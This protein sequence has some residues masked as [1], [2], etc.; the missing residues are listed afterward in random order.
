MRC[1]LV[2]VLGALAGPGVAAAACPD[3]PKAN[4]SGYAPP[5]NTAS[6]P[7]ADAGPEILHRAP[8]VSPQL[9]NTRNWQA[10]PILISGAQ[11]YRGGE[12]VAQDFLYDDRA[13]TYPGDAA[14]ARNAADIVEVRVEPLARATAIRVTL[15]SMVDVDHAAA[16]TVGLGDSDQ[17]RALP[18]NAGVSERAEVFVTAHGCGGDAVRASDT[19]ALPAPTV[20]TDVTRRQV[21]I[22]LPYTAFDPRGRT[23]KV[24]AAAGLWDKNANAYLRP[25][26]ARPAFFNVAFRG[27]GQWTINTWKDESQ[28]AALAAGDLSPLHADV[29]FAKLAAR[30]DDESGVPT[31]GPMNRILVSHFET[32]QGRGNSSGGDIL[33]NYACDPPACTYQ[34]SGRLQPYSVYVPDVAMPKDR[35][36][37]VLTMHGAN[38]NHNHFENGSTEPPLSVWR[39]LAQEGNPSIMVLPNARGMTYCYFGMAGADVFEAWADAAQ[40]YRLDPDQALL[41]GSSMG[42]YGVYKLSSQFPDLFK[43]IFP[44]IAP[45]ICDLTQAA[46][47]LDVV[48]GATNVGRVLAGLRNVPVVATAGLND[49]LV[50]AAITNRTLGRLDA[51]GYRYDFWHFLDRSGQGHVEYRQFVRDTY[52]TLNRSADSVDR[53]PRRVTYVLDTQF[54]DARYGLNSD[55]AY[56]VSGLKLADAGATP[57]VGLIDVTAG[58]IPARRQR[59]GDPERAVGTGI[60]GSAA[61]TRQTRRWVPG[62]PEPISDGFALRAE[63]LSAA[64]LDVRRMRLPEYGSFDGEI[65]SDAPLQLRLTGAFGGATAVTLD[66]RPLS[67]RADGTSVVVAL[68]EGTSKLHVT[69]PVP[70]TTTCRRRTVRVR[71]KAPR[72]DA[73]RSVRVYVN[74]RRV[75]TVTG[76]TRLRRALRVTLKGSGRAQ[77]TVRATTRKGRALVQRHTYR[78]CR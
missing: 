37:L 59:L 23:V 55:H 52:R 30:K 41:S 5:S 73:L 48:P 29:D 47:T 16:I 67:A 42:G 66:G 20:S 45:E 33:G 31:T 68:P 58:D 40:H 36:G 49:P 53:N 65:T 14:Y 56:W 51:F 11:A 39:M 57:P 13:L 4:G 46:S 34:D 8:A 78:T 12:F 60:N 10:Q 70:I 24:S 19:A 54:S 69:Q 35:W 26:P 1:M 50:D 32:V 9:E 43:A 38:S 63:N 64:A 62:D 76:R 3:S 27:F 7:P 21:Q 17:P 74:G 22:E 25:D 77:V 2:L 44:N 18:H 71:V 15:N 6:L 75:K 28:N 61:Y 72:G